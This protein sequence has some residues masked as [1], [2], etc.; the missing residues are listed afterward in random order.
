MVAEAGSMN[1]AAKKLFV[2]Q[3]S[4]STSIK[5]LEEEAGITLFLRS[6]HGVSITPDG[7]EF[8]GYARQVLQQYEL[9][10]TKYIEKKDVK[11]KFSVTMQ[12]YTFA[13]FAFVELVKQYGTDDYE[14][15][16]RESR[17]SEVMEDV[18]N[19][20]SEIGILYLSSFNRDILKKYFRDYE[21]DF[22]PLMQCGVYA[23]VYKD[24][25]LANE[26]SI[27]PRQ[28]TDYTCLTFDQGTEN[29]FYFFEEAIPAAE[30][31]RR[32]IKVSDRATMLN[33]MR[34]LNGYTICCG[35]ICEDLNGSSY[36]A[37]P[38]KYDEM[39]TIGYVCRK[40]AVLSELGERYLEE[41]SKYR[42]YSG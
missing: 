24:H 31:N 22:H 33:L 14:F 16:V 38:I 7:K 42:E 8:I 19:F 34:G 10:E 27:D 13:V 15:A 40:D 30:Y 2:S 4:L 1:E 11:K 26:K 36:K 6:N 3:P 25:P 41:I 21:L 35:I 29:S 32:T 37:V 17:T 5:D 20:T 23:Y 28:L 39:M 12:H 18:K 9:L